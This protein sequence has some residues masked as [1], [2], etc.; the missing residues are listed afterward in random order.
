LL[1]VLNSA[2]SL[3]AS[4]TWGTDVSGSAQGAGGVGG[5]LAIRDVPSAITAFAAYDGNG[6]VTALADAT[7]G[8]ASAQ[9]EYGP[10]G[11]LLS[12]SGAMANAN[13]FRFSTKYQDDETGLL[14]YGYRYYDPPSGRWPNRD[15]IAERG[16]AN[17][18]GFVD[19]NPGNR[20]DAL[21]LQALPVPVPPGAPIVVLPPPGVLP[22]NIIPFP[23][24]PPVVPPVRPIG[25]PQ[26][27]ACVAVAVGGWYLGSTIG[28][29]TGF[30]DA[31]GDWLGGII[32]GPIAGGANGTY[33]G[34]PL[35]AGSPDPLTLPRVNPGMRGGNCNPCP[36]NSPA[37]E[38]NE[39]GHGSTTTHWHWIEYNQLPP[40]HPKHPCECRPIRRSSPTK[41]PGA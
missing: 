32:A 24:P 6:K 25:P 2:G 1:A 21:G 14:Y 16:G 34:S 40:H 28:E 37:W 33:P 26:V 41:P 39:P 35:P 11:E 5:L 17:L 10:F 27:A 29:V 4:F 38:V 3:V 12:T 18:Y 20:F 7:T 13:P 36:P 30:H 23:T 9:Y 22:P 15:P 19:N 8:Q 31:A